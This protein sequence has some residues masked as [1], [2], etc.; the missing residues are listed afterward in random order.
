MTPYDLDPRVMIFVGEGEWIPGT[1]ELAFNDGNSRVLKVAAERGTEH[2]IELP[3][4]AG[5][6]RRRTS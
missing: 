3:R 6:I 2:Y 5:H 1:V 4:Q